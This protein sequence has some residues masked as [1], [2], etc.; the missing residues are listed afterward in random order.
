MKIF[1]P[2]LRN[3]QAILE[4]KIP[5]SFI[6][7][8]YK[9]RLN[10]NV[11]EYLLDVQDVQL[12][13]C[14]DTGFRFYY[15]FNL[16]GDSLFYEQLQNFEWYYTPW[17]WEHQITTN[18][19]S[20]G[21]KILEVGSA[22]GSFLEKIKTQNKVECKGLE[23]NVKAAL[24]GQKKGLDI[25][26][27]SIQEHSKDNNNEYDLVCSFQVL[28]HIADVHS[29][30]KAKITCIKDSGLLVI[31]VPNNSSFIRN[32]SEDILNMPP[33]HM[34]LWGKE[35]LTALT[36]IFPLQLIQIHFEVLQEHHYNWY[37]YL[38]GKKMLWPLKKIYYKFRLDRLLL[39]F[40]K[41]FKIKVTGHTILAVYR[42]F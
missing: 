38:F 25:V 2:L 37:A 20:D 23:L 5:S 27:E 24:E 40:I 32:D 30:I 36:N 26:L 31:S 16:S 21:M 14:C 34:G 22:S 1:S 29:F 35:S 19:I 3:N 11:E 41:F 10:L 9:E 28:E 4:K 18:Y 42:K 15:P 12:Y 39:F 7:K 17:K 6:I 8:K 13:R 33:H